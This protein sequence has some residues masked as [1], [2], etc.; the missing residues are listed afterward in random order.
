MNIHVDIDL[1]EKLAISTISSYQFGSTVYGLADVNSDVDLLHIHVP[2]KQH[3]LSYSWDNSMFQYKEENIDHIFTTIDVFLR[4]LFT[5]DSTI[6]FEILHG[7]NTNK[8]LDYLFDNKHMFYNYSIVRAYLGF[9]KRDLKMAAN[10]NNKL[11]HAIRGYYAAQSIL[12]GDYNLSL[13]SDLIT[14]YS[15]LKGVCDKVIVKEYFAKIDELRI[16]L[17]HLL[18]ANAIRRYSEP[19]DMT[20]LD[21]FLFDLKSSEWY[22][23]MRTDY[24][25]SLL[26]NRLENGVSY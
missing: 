25:T 23:N 16:K 9:A 26:F 14:L 8:H 3:E 5:G 21:E 2:S 24:D 1:F 20:Q 10:G 13:R 6:N 18:D 19:K 15:T 17:N 22:N 4:N 12:E 7:T 11:Y